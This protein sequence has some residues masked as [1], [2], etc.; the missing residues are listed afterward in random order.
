MLKLKGIDSRAP[1][2]RDALHTCIQKLR[3]TSKASARTP[4]RPAPTPGTQARQAAQA[5]SRQPITP[6]HSITHVP[7]R[8]TSILHRFTACMRGH[9]VPAFPEPEG[10]AFNVSRAGLNPASPVYKA[11][12]SE[13]G[14][15]LQAVDPAGRG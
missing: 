15:I 10:A 7:A 3:S 8:V 2:Y 11:A 4:T 5:T 1:G 14:Q 6:R 9:G 12:E 13:C